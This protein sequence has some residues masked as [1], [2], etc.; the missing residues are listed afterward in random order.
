[1]LEVCILNP[2]QFMRAQPIKL[3]WFICSPTL[4]TS[5]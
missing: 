1:M 5:N 4:V 2:L 3:H